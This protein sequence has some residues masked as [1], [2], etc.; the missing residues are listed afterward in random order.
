M[1]IRLICISILLDMRKKHKMQ[2]CDLN[3][4]LIP[5]KHKAHLLTISNIRLL[6]TFSIVIALTMLDNHL[7]KYASFCVRICLMLNSRHQISS[8]VHKHKLCKKTIHEFLQRHYNT[9]VCWTLL[10]YIEDRYLCII[11]VSILVFVS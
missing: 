7:V 1:S 6:S 5:L 9:G 10:L 8:H 2:V 4:E 3:I 11:S